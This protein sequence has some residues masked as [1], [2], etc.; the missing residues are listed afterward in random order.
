MESML[1]LFKELEIQLLVLLSFIIQ[2]LLFFTG[3]LRRHSTSGFLRLCIW[4]TY[5]GADVVAVYSLGLL[6]RH[7]DATMEKHV[8][9]KT[10]PLSFFW[11]PFLLIHL[12][13][14]DTITAFAMEDNNLWLRNLLNLVMQVVL[15]LYVFWISIGR[16]N[17]ELLVSGILAFTA[18]IKY[19]ERTWCLKCGCLKSLESSTGQA[20]KKLLPKEINGHGYD[21]IVCEALGSTRYVLDI[22]SGRSLLAENPFSR[23]STL[24]DT[25]RMLKVVR[26]ELGVMYD[27]L[28][29]KALVLR[30]RSI[31]ILRCISQISAVVAF[32]LFHIDD[33]RGYNKSDIAVAYSLFMGGFFLEVCSVFIC[34]MS[35]WTWAWL[36]VRK[37]GM[38]ASLSWF[39]FSSE[40]GWPEEKQRWPKSMGQYNLVSW[41]SAS[42]HHLHPRT[43][44]Q[45][46]M[47]SSNHLH[48]RTFSRRVMTVCRR[49]LV[50]VIGVK[51]EKIFWI[52]K[53]L[54]TEQVDV[55][56]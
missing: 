5:L 44:S 50:D 16:H 43:F 20:Y 30:T 8:L 48:P 12:G 19:G 34:L 52:S 32:V 33:K 24:G 31:V 35:P 25:N 17:V 10:Q 1:E 51:K 11:A 38:L 14:Q 13:G 45:R 56:R 23:P 27:D 53:M 28:Y 3:S 4:A 22:F 54:E 55:E 21:S 37:C 42:S 36:K 15:A 26:I 40:I 9:S 41:L 18:G 49:L 7:E 29:T 6:S 47:N 46:V 39:I 2:F